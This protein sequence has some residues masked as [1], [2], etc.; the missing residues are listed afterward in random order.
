[1]RPLTQQSAVELLAL[2]RARN[3]SALE[4]AEEY[5]RQVER[6]NPQITRW[7][8]DGIVFAIRRA[9]TTQRPKGPP[10]RT[11]YIVDRDRGPS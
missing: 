11:V 4:L 2:L 8:T 7:W 3:I 1:M 6:L 10:R 5:I 9:P